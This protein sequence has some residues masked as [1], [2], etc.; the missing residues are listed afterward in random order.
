MIPFYKIKALGQLVVSIA[1]KGDKPK[2]ADYPSPL[3]DAKMWS[4]FESCWEMEASRRP[5]IDQVLTVLQEISFERGK[6]Y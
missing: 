4:L 1:V 2:F 3:I 6:N 5:T